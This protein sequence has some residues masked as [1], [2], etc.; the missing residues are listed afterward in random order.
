MA[1]GMKTSFIH[2][3]LWTKLWAQRWDTLTGFSRFPSF[4]PGKYEILSNVIVNF[5]LRYGN[6]AFNATVDF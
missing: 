5:H 6:V 1:S 2:I 4:S 3:R